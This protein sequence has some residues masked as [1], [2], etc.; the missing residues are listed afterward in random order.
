[1]RI[2][3][4]AR[5]VLL[6]G[7]AALT[8]CDRTPTDLALDGVIDAALLNASVENPVFAQSPTSLA[9]LLRSAIAKVESERG[10]GASR[11]LLENWQ[12]LQD[13]ARAAVR[14]G[15]R[16]EAMARIE[17]IRAEEIRI[18]LLV[19]GEP[20]AQRVISAVTAAES[21]LRSDLTRAEA[22]GKDVMRARELAVPVTTLL[23]QAV[24]ALQARDPAKALDFATQASDRL[25]VVTHYL[26]ALDR[27]P[28]VETLF[29]DAVATVTREQGRDAT[30]TLLATL[31]QLKD[32]ARAA[33]LAGDRAETG[34][35]LEA[36]RR[37]QIRIVMELLGEGVV[38]TMIQRVDAGIVSTR[39]RLANATEPRLV[40]HARRM[41]TEAV[42][43]NARAKA[44]RTR[45]DQIGAL[46]L[47]SHAAGLINALRHFVLDR[48]Q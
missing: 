26:I 35:K 10:A 41:L 7:L 36:V 30:T 1:M 43:L 32:E 16:A 18:V 45:D 42:D 15:N 27:I 17:A 24:R 39:T 44:L 34:R 8:G 9:Q 22:A 12:K 2:V 23:Q 47:A 37:E 28:T 6:V 5:V 4:R 29:A 11:R 38:E 3:A 33:M 19:L 13:E 14:A 31:N 40:E 48:G 25:D 20:T 21:R 46:D